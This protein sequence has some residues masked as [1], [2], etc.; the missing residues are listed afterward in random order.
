[1]PAIEKVDFKKTLK[2]AFTASAKEMR[3]VELP[4]FTYL[5]IEGLGFEEGNPAYLQAIEALYSV[6]YTLKFMLKKPELQ[7][8]GYFEFVVPPMESQMWQ[9]DPNAPY[10]VETRPNWRWKTLLLQ[11]D[12]MNEDLLAKAKEEL[13]KKKALPALS[14][15]QL[16]VYLAGK[17]AQ[18]LHVGPYD[19]VGSCIKKLRAAMAAEGLSPTRKHHEVYLSDPRRTAPEKLKTIVRYYYA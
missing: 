9:D 6:A 10:T 11:A 8:E 19:E 18:M 2:P 15:L 1:M 3:L 12:F 16:E 14:A 13:A 4:A 5:S 17:A 7:P